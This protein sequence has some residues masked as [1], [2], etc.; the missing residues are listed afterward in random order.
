MPVSGVCRG[1][2]EDDPAA[3]GDGWSDLVRREIQRE[4]ERRDS[5]DHTDRDA[6]RPTAPAHAGRV[7]VDH[8]AAAGQR[9]R[10]RGRE[11]DGLDGAVDLHQRLGDG[12]ASLQC[13][14]AGQVLAALAHDRG[15]PVEDLGA[16]VGREPGGHGAGGGV[17]RGPGRVGA[18]HWHLADESSVVGRPDLERH[19][20]GDPLACDVE[21]GDLGREL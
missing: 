2:L 16:P 1:G 17:D 14:R 11:G 21:R 8:H 19:A 5:A 4:V 7:G 10:L 6:D 9:P 15:G 20:A 13:E 3:G 18:H 12:L